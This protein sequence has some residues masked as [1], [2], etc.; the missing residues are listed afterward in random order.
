[1]WVNCIAVI[2]AAAAIAS[3]ATVSVVVDAQSGRWLY[4]NGGVN[5]GEQYGINDQ[6]SPTII[7]SSSGISFAAGTRLAIIYVSGLT[8]PIQVFPL[9][10]TRQATQYCLDQ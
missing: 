2:F 1:M 4:T 10:L 9:M 7:D 6:S 8:S 5:T 3:A